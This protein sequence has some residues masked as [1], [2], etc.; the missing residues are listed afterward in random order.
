MTPNFRFAAAGLLP[1]CLCLPAAAQ[2]QRK[3]DLSLDGTTTLADRVG[4]CG[5]TGSR[6]NAYYW[7]GEQWQ[8]G[9]DVALE[10]PGTKGPSTMLT[11]QI[12]EW[13]LSYAFSQCAK[14][15]EAEGLQNAALFGARD[16]G[17]FVSVYDNGQYLEYT[18]GQG[19]F[20]QLYLEPAQ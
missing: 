11:G 17:V 2:E 7:D 8:Y 10:A 1:L 13:M 3:L 5:V 16:S 4:D 12:G 19:G 18:D 15:D 20:Q 14:P 9:G 6:F